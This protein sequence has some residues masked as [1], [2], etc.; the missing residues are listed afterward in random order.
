MNI[1]PEF[2]EFIVFFLITTLFL[3]Y[4]SSIAQE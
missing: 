1:E 2:K 3:E 4:A